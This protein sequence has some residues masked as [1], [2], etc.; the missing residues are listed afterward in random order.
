MH[1][2]LGAQRLTGRV[3]LLEDTRLVPGSSALAQL[4]LDETTQAVYGDRV[5]LRDQSVWHT[6]GGGVVLD[7]THRQGS[8]AHQHDWRNCKRCNKAGSKSHCQPCLA[9]P[10]TAWRQ[11]P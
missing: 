3:A 2:H 1:V 5:V 7:P 8:G 10:I 11:R 4:V 9:L 6:L